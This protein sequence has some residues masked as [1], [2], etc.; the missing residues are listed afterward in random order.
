VLQKFL[1]AIS[2]AFLMG[3]A[4]AEA[5]E[6]FIE[7]FEALD[8]K[9]WYLSHGWAN[10]DH[11]ACTW[12]NKNIRVENRQLIL[13]LRP[14]KSEKRNFS[15][16]ELQSKATFGFGTYEV[17]ARA[18][19]GSGVVTGFFTYSG[20]P[21]PNPHDEIDFEWL[22]RD[23]NAVQTNYFVNGQ[24]IGG[25]MHPVGPDG[26]K[27]AHNYAFEWLPDSLRWY[28]D[29]KLVREVQKAADAPYPTHS[30]KIL[31][32]LWNSDTLVDWLGPLEDQTATATASFEWIAFTAAGEKCHFRESILCSQ[33]K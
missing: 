2:G 7:R 8:H 19:V 27:T 24:S 21:Q 4:C 6:S 22:G 17:R 32:S 3:F 23:V 9:R 18:A 14:E 28:I 26:A 30:S 20:P 25:A 31:V 1:T 11:Q 5:G 10:G 12:S 33:T 16:S 15:C 13:T 29:G